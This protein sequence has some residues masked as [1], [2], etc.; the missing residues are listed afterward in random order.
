MIVNR[1][2]ATA[3]ERY[4]QKEHQLRH[5]RSDITSHRNVPAVS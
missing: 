5:V 4:H 3:G 1:L 2:A